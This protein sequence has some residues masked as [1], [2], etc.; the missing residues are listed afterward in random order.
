MSLL[1]GVKGT[2][3]LFF[4]H[5]NGCSTMIVLRISRV[6][7]KLNRSL[8]SSTVFFS[9]H[10]TDLEATLLLTKTTKNL[11]LIRIRIIRILCG[12]SISTLKN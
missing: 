1:I 10:R 6:S 8:P 2:N 5:K 4:C 12:W 7:V 3:A 9:M 11:K